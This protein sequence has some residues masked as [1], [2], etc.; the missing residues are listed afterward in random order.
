MGVSDAQLRASLSKQLCTYSPDIRLQFDCI[1]A[2]SRVLST[3]FYTQT[4]RPHTNI[5][6]MRSHVKACSLHRVIDKS[7]RKTPLRG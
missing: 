2:R 5:N 6:Y 1:P 3:S 4:L 7:S